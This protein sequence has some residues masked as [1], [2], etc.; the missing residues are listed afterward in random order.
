MAIRPLAK[1]ILGTSVA[2]LSGW[3]T[4]LMFLMLMGIIEL[5]RQPHFIAPEALIVG[6]ILA[7]G[8]MAY[9]VVPIWLVILIPLYLF[10]PASSVLWR[11]PVCTAAGVVAG[12]AVMTFFFGG[13]PG[14]GQVSVGAWSF[15]VMAAIVGGITCLTG[16]LTRHRF[17]RAT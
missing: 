17:K 14:L 13:L 11:W 15:Y 9:F 8:F 2:V 3:L 6:P 12:L 10:V 16:S 5:L 7:S 4:S 1:Q